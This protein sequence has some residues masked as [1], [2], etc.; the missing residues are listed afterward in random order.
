[1]SASVEL[2]DLVLAI[3]KAD[4]GVGALVGDRIYDQAPGGAAFPHLTL[5]PSDYAPRDADCIPG[6]EETLQI[7]VWHRDG[8]RLWP[9]RR[10]A[11]AVKDALHD[12]DGELATQALADLRVTLV[13]VIED[14][15]GITAHGVVQVTATIEEVS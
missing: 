7:D 3:L 8:G 13:R 9:C 1:V 15:D 10:T 14:P 2:S 4:A 5:G 12:R 6:R 11:D